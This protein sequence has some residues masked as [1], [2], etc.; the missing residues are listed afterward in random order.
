[1]IRVTVLD[2]GAGNLRSVHRSLAAVGA[3]VTTS[4]DP[5]VIAEATHLVVPGQGAF[6]DCM[7]RLDRQGLANTLFPTDRRRL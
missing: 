4:A 7:T 1:M 5:Q 2:H 6:G 3:E